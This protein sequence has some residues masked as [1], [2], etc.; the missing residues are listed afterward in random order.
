MLNLVIIRHGKSSWQD[1]DLEDFERPL[2]ERGRSDLITM[3][4]VLEDRFPPPERIL[5][6]S[7]VR[8][9]QTAEGIVARWKQPGG[10]VRF[11]DDLYL[12][13]SEDILVILRGQGSRGTVYICGHNPGISEFASRICGR[14]L[15]YLP[16]LAS[17][18]IRIDAPEDTDHYEWRHI[19]W[20]DGALVELVTPKSLASD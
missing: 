10:E 17:A 19:D 9:R 16:T 18:H 12:A 8:A 3:S 4:K 2:N 6:S 5:C 7:A 14:D 20:G 15:G 11:I 1:R 13:E